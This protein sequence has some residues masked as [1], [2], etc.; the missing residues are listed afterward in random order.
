MANLSETLT[1]LIKQRRLSTSELARQ[2][3]VAQPVIYR[4]MTGATTN[5]Q[6][7]SLKPVADYLGISIDQLMG[8]KALDAQEPL[9]TLL[10]HDIQN[11]LTT[12]KTI[13]S[14][15]AE[16]FPKLS[17]AYKVGL[18]NGLV[19]QELPLELLPMIDFNISSL[20]K[21]ADFVTKALKIER[22]DKR[23]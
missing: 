18:H 21:S 1:Y 17:N 3:G 13:A 4:M 20:T 16:I 7:L 9:N 23:E 12:I 10:L 2:T 8:Y 11:R 14:A 15:L 6:V 22:S 19:A 5:P